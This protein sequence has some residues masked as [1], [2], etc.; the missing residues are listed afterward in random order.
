MASPPEAFA[1]LIKQAAAQYGVDEGL[2]VRTLHKESGFAPDVVDGRRVSSAG[3]LGVAQ[4]MPDTAK[5]FGINPLDPAQAI[6]ASARYLAENKKLLGNDGL[7]LAGYNWGEGNVQRWLASGADPRR[8]P[9]ET[10][11]YV[12]KITGRPIEAWAQAGRQGAPAAAPAE[13][14]GAMQVPPQMGG[15]RDPVTRELLKAQL[16]DKSQRGA[17]VRT[18]VER[19][20]KRAGP[21]FEH[22]GHTL[23]ADGEGR[24]HKVLDPQDKFAEEIDSQGNKFSINLRTGEKKLMQAGDPTAIKARALGMEPT[25]PRVQA[26]AFKPEG[27]MGAADKKAVLE[28]DAKISS[29]GSVK[30]SLARAK[31]LNNST[32]TGGLANIKAT[33]GDQW[34]SFVPDALIDPR[35]AKN[36]A[37]WAK[38]MELPALEKMSEILK[39]PTTNFEM[40]KFIAM[41][42]DPRT[43]KAT[44][45]RILDELLKTADEAE[46]M[47]KAQSQDIRGGTYFNPGSGPTGKLPAGVS[48]TQAVAEARAVWKTANPLQRAQIQEQL[49][50]WGVNVDLGE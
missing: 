1:P 2:L 22:Q 32:F 13:A 45:A 25:D 44:R 43:D 38:I 15:L 23:Q 17:A 6:P 37:E 10:R 46:A 12:M 34:D 30:R 50:T 18:I 3:A 40:G 9:G 26:S 31:E 19:R 14:G 21:T 48:A 36:T 49:R 16:R 20:S 29:I 47:A 33:L 5:R 39:G 11:D 41:L 27:R 8:V 7:A 4:F 35:T 28:A 24:V 42:A